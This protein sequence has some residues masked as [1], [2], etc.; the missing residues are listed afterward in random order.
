MIGEV[1]VQ[2]LK[3]HIPCPKA[4]SNR[5]RRDKVEDEH[6]IETI[7]LTRNGAITANAQELCMSPESNSS[8]SA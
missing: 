7:R 2:R 8:L 3:G 1:G 4:I 6:E 5:I